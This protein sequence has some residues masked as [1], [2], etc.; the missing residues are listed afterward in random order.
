MLEFAFLTTW[1]LLFYISIPVPSPSHIHPSPFTP[2]GGWCSP[3]GS[4]KSVKS[5]GVG[6]RPSLL[7]LAPLASVIFK[8]KIDTDNQCHTISDCPQQNPCSGMKVL[9]EKALCYRIGCH[10]FLC[11][12]VFLCASPLFTLCELNATVAME[13]ETPVNKYRLFFLSI[14]FLLF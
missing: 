4:T 13:F 5:F 9:Q 8:D 2:Q 14:W 7:P 3:G 6:S 1:L 11:D 10:F 12:T